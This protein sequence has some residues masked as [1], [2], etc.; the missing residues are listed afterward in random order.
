MLEPWINFTWYNSS[1]FFHAF[2]ESD[3]EG[4]IWKVKFNSRIE[5]IGIHESV[6]FYRSNAAALLA[7]TEQ[8]VKTLPRFINT[9][10][11][12]V[13]FLFSRYRLIRS[14]AYNPK[15]QQTKCLIRLFF[16][17]PAT[18]K[19][20]FFPLVSLILKLGISLSLYFSIFLNTA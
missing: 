10:L 16:Q 9:I 2:E 17:P 15:I 8:T 20:S 11:F 12:P 3:Y 5:E 4:K 18:R 1:L 19:L 13:V 7:T 14:F 6:A